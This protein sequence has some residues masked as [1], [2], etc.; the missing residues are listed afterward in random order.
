ARI[1]SPKTLKPEN[2]A[3]ASQIED[4]PGTAA[5]PASARVDADSSFENAAAERLSA[6]A[7]AAVRAAK[8]RASAAV[9]ALRVESP[10]AIAAT[11][12]FPA[13]KAAKLACMPH[14]G[15]ST[16]VVT[17]MPVAPPSV[18]AA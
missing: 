15:A 10:H 8:P 9:A 14:F 2:A 13:I 3:S 16:N 11:A 17:T 6:T 4:M 5:P 12:A 1:S 18:F 7:G